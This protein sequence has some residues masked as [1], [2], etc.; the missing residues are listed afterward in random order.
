MARTLLNKGGVALSDGLLSQLD[1]ILYF[2]YLL[3]LFLKITPL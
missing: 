3:R 2:F 1:G